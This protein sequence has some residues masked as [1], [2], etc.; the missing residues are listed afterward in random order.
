MPIRQVKVCKNKP[1][2][3]SKGGQ[4]I[5]IMYIFNHANSYLWWLKMSWFK[6]AHL[7]RHKQ[8]KDH[9]KTAI[10]I[11]WL[12]HGTTFQR[13]RL[14]ELPEPSRGHCMS[15][16]LL[17]SLAQ[18]IAGCPRFTRMWVWIS[19]TKHST[20]GRKRDMTGWD[21]AHKRFCEFGPGY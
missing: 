2:S 16:F 10:S 6:L 19:T 8:R 14:L 17:M 11:I 5:K 13:A 7:S 1:M 3:L 15:G 18:Q 21:M 4:H 20:D 12:Q 9:I